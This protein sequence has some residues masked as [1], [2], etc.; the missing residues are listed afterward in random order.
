MATVTAKLQNYGTPKPPLCLDLILKD[1]YSIKGL[2]QTPNSWLLQ[3]SWFAILPMVL[4]VYWSLS[5]FFLF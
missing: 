5:L 1:V 4:C 3:C 2:D